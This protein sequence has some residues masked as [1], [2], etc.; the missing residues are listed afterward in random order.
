MDKV[1]V[2]DF[3]SSIGQYNVE[4]IKKLL[5]KVKRQHIPLSDRI[6]P[7]LGSILNALYDHGRNENVP[8]EQGYWQ[9]VPDCG[10]EILELLRPYYDFGED[11]K[12]VQKHFLYQPI[13]H[14]DMRMLE[15][16]WELDPLKHRH[17]Q[18]PYGNLM[19]Y[20]ILDYCY[21]RLPSWEGLPESEGGYTLDLNS[22]HWL[23]TLYRQAERCC[24]APPEH[25]DFLMKHD[26]TP[27]GE[28]VSLQLAPPRLKLETSERIWTITD[29]R[30]DHRQGVDFEEV[31]KSVLRSGEYESL[32][33]VC[34]DPWCAGV[35]QPVL[36]M[37][38]GDVARWRITQSE[39]D[40]DPKVY[41]L[42]VPVREYISEAEILL[43]KIEHGILTDGMNDQMDIDRPITDFTPTPRGLKKV[44][45][46][47]SL[48][49]LELTGQKIPDFK[50]RQATI[51]VTINA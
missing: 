34:G 26:F 35:Y 21:M 36:S 31:I 17:F 43:E 41:Y 13:M 48:I 44:Q 16:L 37:R 23:E 8:F 28:K 27:Y 15:Y 49:Q 19:R 10:Y 20:A 9:I 24:I 11:E 29:C 32:T 47:R 50:K 45:N 1:C 30:I 25:L 18:Q 5:R 12:L 3:L 46:I 42:A 38:F 7:K 22:D 51:F 39:D 2:Y 33:C 14:G 6:Y 4:A 40:N